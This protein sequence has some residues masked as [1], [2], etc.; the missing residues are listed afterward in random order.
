MAIEVRALPDTPRHKILCVDDET[1]VLEGLSLQLGRRYEVLTALSGAEALEILQREDRIAVLISDMRMPRM[2]GAEFLARA[3]TIAPNAARILLTGQTDL[4]SAIA[5]VNDAQ[6]LKFL[7]KPC[8]PPELHTAVESAIE[9]HR[10]ASGA[11]TGLRRTLTAQIISQDAV[12]GL[13]SRTHFNAALS[14]ACAEASEPVNREQVRA[15]AVLFVIIENLGDI[16][17]VL[18]HTVGDQV[19]E[20]LA[21]RLREQCEKAL[22]I[23]RWGDEEFAVLMLSESGDESSLVAASD[24]LIAQLAAPIALQSITQRMRACIGI[25]AVPAHTTDA[26]AAIKFAALAARQA[27]LQGGGVSCLFRSDWADRVEYRY[28]LLVALREAMDSNALHLNYQPVIDIKQGC[29]RKLEALARWEHPT[30]G[31]ISPQQFINLAEESGDM[32]RLGQWILRRACCEARQLVGRCCARVAVNV[33]MQQLLHDNFLTQ[34]D[35]ILQFAQLHPQE[36]ELELTESVFSQDADRVLAVVTELHKLG[37]T[38]SID[39]FGSGYSSLAY[40]QRFPADAI[41][42]DRSF[43]A[44]L[45]KGG[46]TII[47]A[48][49]S[50]GRSFGMEV[51]IEGVE[52]EMQRRQLTALGATLFQGYLYGKPMPLAEV[53]P[54]F[55]SSAFAAAPSEVPETASTS[56]PIVIR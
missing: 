47:A 15:F 49:L 14:A 13:A 33:S 45:G 28:Q 2:D 37:I 10:Q 9:H 24:A 34:L 56:P 41:K 30:M 32:P 25:V 40:L 50:I 6:V 48:A 17:A 31:P 1:Q 23:G 4:R 19:L 11:T 51:V 5:A 26:K 22:C 29:V 16:N 46:E 42:V 8:P 39:D 53:D 27:K 38:V 55:L 43:V 18:G 21:H 36:L 52:T 20:V 12:T 7:S 3:R 35:E 44:T 54:W